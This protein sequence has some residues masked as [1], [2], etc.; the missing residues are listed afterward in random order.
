MPFSLPASLSMIV[1]LALATG[2]ALW[3]GVTEAA[4]CLGTV[5]LVYIVATLW[6]WFIQPIHDID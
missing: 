3:L 6:L 1:C 4:W 2:I 5:A